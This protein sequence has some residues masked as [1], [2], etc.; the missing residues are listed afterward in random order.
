LYH[1]PAARETYACS[2]VRRDPSYNCPN[3]DLTR[4]LRINDTAGNP[5]ALRSNNESPRTPRRRARKNIMANIQYDVAIV[6][7]GPAG[8]TAAILLAKKGRSVV[9]VDRAKF[10]RE[11]TCAGWLSARS[12]SLLEA[13]PIKPTAIGQSAFRDVTFY[14]P[15]FS[16]SAKPR[17]EDIPGYLIDRTRFDNELVA[18]AGSNDVSVRTC[19]TA[20]D[21]RLDESS[22]TIDLGDD[23]TLRSRLLILAAGRNTKL[24]DRVGVATGSN[25]SL[26]WTAQV[27]QP[28]TQKVAPKKSSVDVV[29]GLDNGGSFGLICTTKQRISIGVHWMGERLQAVPTLVLLCRRAAEHQAV[30]V[31]LSEQARAAL[32]ISS[33]ASAALDRDTHVGKHTLV[34]GDAGGFISA[35]SNEGIYPA[36]WSAQIAAEVIDKALYS[37]HS[38]DELMTFDSL[39][40]IQM[41]DYLRS[42]H[43]DIQFLLPLIFNNQPMAD[44]MGA[45]FFLGENI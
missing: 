39:W 44:R 18:T 10:P 14:R 16:E 5:I 3:A 23:G 15:D 25:E 43:T 34:I 24:L 37:V 8:A 1:P 9:L 22:V 21:I 4:S 40:R 28:L 26:F 31:D 2:D 41:A 29:L 7:A 38:Q 11:A 17:F 12:A 45:A 30:P 33:P 36:M 13:L 20:V 19:C 35:A 32:L 27:D 6:G 42:P